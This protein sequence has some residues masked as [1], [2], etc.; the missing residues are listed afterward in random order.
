MSSTVFLPLAI[1]YASMMAENNANNDER[2]Y[3]LA[4]PVSRN[5]Y[6]TG[7]LLSSFINSL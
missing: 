2:T 7:K 1:F 3:I 6:M 4:R 5:D